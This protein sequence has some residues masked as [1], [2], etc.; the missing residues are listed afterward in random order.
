M[1]KAL[2]RLEQQPASGPPGSGLDIRDLEIRKLVG[3]DFLLSSIEGCML[4]GDLAVDGSEKSLA[5]KGVSA[6]R[7]SGLVLIWPE[8]EKGLWTGQNS[9]A[10][11]NRGR[12][13]IDASWEMND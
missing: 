3:L 7:S 9:G 11:E 5:R 1:R 10:R 12:I 4:S 6:G 8:A 2:N 13:L